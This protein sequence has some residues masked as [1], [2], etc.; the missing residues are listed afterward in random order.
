M[1][2]IEA[3][4]ILKKSFINL[5][6]YSASIQLDIN[7]FG[8]L[9]VAYKF[10]RDIFLLLGSN[11]NNRE[12]SLSDAWKL[13]NEEIGPVQNSSSV[14]ETAAWGKKDQ[15]AFLN[16][17]LY[18]KSDVSARELLNH[19]LRIEKLLGR[20]R[21]EHWGART[22]DID[23]LF[24]GEEIIKQFDLIIPH[25]LLHERRFVLKPLAEIAPDLLHPII[26]KSINQL[27]TELTDNLS[28]IRLV[29]HN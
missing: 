8:T 21:I 2:N 4:T 19:V 26:K 11:L 10:M 23:I 16:Q 25:Q 3:K 1:P 22:I 7:I 5:I 12:K 20:K 13:I 18:L 24:Y 6:Y 17:V 27:L 9:Q 15:P 14:Y 28:V 29:N